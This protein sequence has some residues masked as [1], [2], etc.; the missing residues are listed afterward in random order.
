MGHGTGLDVSVVL[1][2][3]SLLSRFLEVKKVKWIV[4]NSW[5]YAAEERS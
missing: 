2:T 5:G 4:V 3:A 1:Y